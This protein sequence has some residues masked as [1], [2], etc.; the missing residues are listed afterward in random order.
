MTLR[1]KHTRTSHIIKIQILNFQS[2][3]FLTKGQAFLYLLFLYLGIFIFGVKVDLAYDLMSGKCANLTIEKATEQNKS[4]GN[5]TITAFQE[6]DLII[7]DM[8]YFAVA[9]FEA[10]ERLLRGY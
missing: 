7:R 2:N 6:G 3:N 10:I 5:E 9:G 4:I 8:G 1:C